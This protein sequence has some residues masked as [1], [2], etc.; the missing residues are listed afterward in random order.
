[1]LLPPTQAREAAASYAF[2]AT[3][4][5]ELAEFYNKLPLL[6]VNIRVKRELNP[7]VRLCRSTTDLL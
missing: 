6:F 5:R 2:I 7:K 1:M 4:A 3:Q